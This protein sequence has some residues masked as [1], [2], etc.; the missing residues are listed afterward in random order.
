MNFILLRS[1]FS[2]VVVAAGDTARKNLNFYFDWKIK[3]CL[4]ICFEYSC[5]EVKVEAIYN[6]IALS[7]YN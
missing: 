6:A 4:N 1:N 2:L 7:F 5:F 3:Q